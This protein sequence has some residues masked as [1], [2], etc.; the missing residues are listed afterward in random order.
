MSLGKSYFEKSVRPTLRPECG[1][2]CSGCGGSHIGHRALPN[3]PVNG[4]VTEELWCYTCKEL[5]RS[6]EVYHKQ[7]VPLA[8]AA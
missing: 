7:H 3:V 4:T 8:V 6:D 5:M 2:E 1:W